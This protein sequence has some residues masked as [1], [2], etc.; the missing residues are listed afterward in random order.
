MCLNPQPFYQS[1]KNCNTRG[2]DSSLHCFRKN[3]I[4]SLDPQL[5][6]QLLNSAHL[7]SKY[8]LLSAERIGVSNLQGLWADG[9]ISAWNG[10]YHFNIN[11]QMTYWPVYAM[12][13]N[14]QVIPPFVRFLEKL[15]RHGHR[16]AQELYGCEGWVVHA[17]TDD[18]LGTG[19]LGDLEWSLCVTCNQFPL[20]LDSF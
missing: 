11:L 18:T 10:D 14:K 6:P 1:E 4:Q 7:F 3:Y 2:I 16:T 9:P 15:I 13:I 12:G 17:F 19:V 8:L 5:D 20:S